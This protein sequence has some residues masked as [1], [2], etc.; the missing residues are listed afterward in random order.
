MGK[1]I[2]V[3][4]LDLPYIDLY[5]QNLAPE[6]VKFLRGNVRI[7]DMSFLNLEGEPCPGDDLWAFL[8]LHDWAYNELSELPENHKITAVVDH[9]EFESYPEGPCRLDSIRRV[10]RDRLRS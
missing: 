7:S 1:T 4:L 6:L 9:V 2:I 8:G 10:N 5:A 3:P